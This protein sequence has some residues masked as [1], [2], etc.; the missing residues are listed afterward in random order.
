MRG[1]A[2]TEDGGDEDVLYMNVTVAMCLEE[3]HG[4]KAI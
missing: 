2:D 4:T 3:L 1:T